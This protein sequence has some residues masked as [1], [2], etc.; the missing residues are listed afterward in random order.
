M[1]IL[2]DWGIAEGQARTTGLMEVNRK[3]RH[4]TR[5]Q[6]SLAASYPPNTGHDYIGLRHARRRH[7]G[8]ATDTGAHRLNS[9]GGITEKI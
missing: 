5:A 6:R 3:D 1:L 8:P 9:E 2:D 7:P 4:W